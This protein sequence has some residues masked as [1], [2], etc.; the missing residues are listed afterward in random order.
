VIDTDYIK[1]VMTYDAP[2]YKGH[3]AENGYLGFGM[4]Y[5]AI[6]YMLKA[7]MCVCLG[8]GGGFVPRCMRQ[9]QRDLHLHP[10]QTIL[11]DN[12]SGKWGQ[13]NWSSRDSFFREAWRDIDLWV[14]DTDDAHRQLC[15]FN[16][17]VDY[18]H[19]DADHGPQVFDDFWHFAER[20]T[21]RGVITMHDTMTKCSV[22]DLVKEIRK[23]P[24]WELVNFPD[25]GAG[26]A[27]VRK[28][29]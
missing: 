13:A 4:V 27:I 23:D 20:L 8:S 25:V 29:R 17:C 24:G 10:S 6:A 19:I 7:R 9:A 18:C 28:V 16:Q 15:D 2:Y 3:G 5:Y 11:V 12:L 26:V 1:A 14:M 22:P 21:E